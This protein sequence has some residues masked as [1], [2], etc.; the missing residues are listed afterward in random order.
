MLQRKTLPGLMICGI[1]TCIITLV[2]LLNFIL[3]LAGAAAG[4]EILLL[5]SGGVSLVFIF[6]PFITAFLYLIFS[7]LTHFSVGKAVAC[8]MIIPVTIAYEFAAA[9][10]FVNSPYHDPWLALSI[11]PLVPVVTLCV[12]AIIKKNSSMCW[13]ATALLFGIWS[14][15][16]AFL[17]YADMWETILF[18]HGC[19]PFAV[20]CAFI[21]GDLLHTV[22]AKRR[23]LP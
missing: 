8:L 15:I 16:S 3:A 14:G 23:N 12:L 13:G 4:R 11:L 22:K 2:N 17:V 18:L 7:A 21:I 9:Y 10:L 6:A 5:R 20:I 1:L 19:F